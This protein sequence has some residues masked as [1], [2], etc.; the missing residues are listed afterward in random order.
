MKY[1]F[2]PIKILGGTPRF[3]A[4]AQCKKQIQDVFDRGLNHCPPPTG[5]TGSGMI[6]IMSLEA[7][8]RDNYVAKKGR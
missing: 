8:S 4:R 5:R 6:K 2:K 7:A 3:C 1:L